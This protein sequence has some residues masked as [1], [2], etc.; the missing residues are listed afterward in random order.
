MRQEKVKAALQY[1]I[2]HG[3]NYADLIIEDDVM[4]QLPE[5]GSVANRILTCCDG[6]QDGG[7][8]PVD[9]GAAA[10]DGEGDEGDELRVGGVM[11]IGNQDRPEVQ[12]L[13]VL[14]KPFTPCTALRIHPG[15]HYHGL[16]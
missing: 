6:R 10:T 7:P 16:P 15:I 1:K 12:Q 11:D 13:V 8:V 2:A 9:P 14:R 4:R 5:N 3:P